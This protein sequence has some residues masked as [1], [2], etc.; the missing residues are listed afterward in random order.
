MDRQKH[1]K[2]SA[3]GKW[4]SCRSARPLLLAFLKHFTIQADL[5]ALAV[6]VDV[7]I[8]LLAPLKIAGQLFLLTQSGRHSSY[9]IWKSPSLTPCLL[10]NTGYHM[11][12]L[13]LTSNAIIPLS[14]PIIAQ[15]RRLGLLSNPVQS[16]LLRFRLR[17]RCPF[18]V[19]D[20]SVQRACEDATRQ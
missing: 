18:H 1:L 19:L 7:A 3:H 8:A 14:S 16:L 5:M 10:C 12:I 4:K 11:L 15:Y 9:Q 17:L 6:N 2:S 20:V 13:E